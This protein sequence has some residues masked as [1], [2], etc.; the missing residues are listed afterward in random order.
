MMIKKVRTLLKRQQGFTLIELLVVIAIIGILAA[1]AIPKYVDSTASANGAKIISDLQIIDSAIQ[2]YSADHAGAIPT[3][4]DL[5]GG[6]KGDGTK[7]FATTP[8]PPTGKFK[9][10]GMSDPVDISTN[11]YGVNTDG[12]ATFGEKTVDQLTELGKK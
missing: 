1:I 2:Q 3:Y 6:E 11:A 10:S 5:T 12:R 9:V 4:A 7:Y 8:K